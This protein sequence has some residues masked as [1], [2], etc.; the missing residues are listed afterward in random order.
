MLFTEQIKV[1]EEMKPMV[2]TVV[3][4]KGTFIF[5]S[6]IKRDTEHLAISVLSTLP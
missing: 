2:P 5:I 4:T 1:K 3:E 6:V